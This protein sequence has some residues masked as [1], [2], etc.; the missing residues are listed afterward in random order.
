MLP[1]VP[2]AAPSVV[3]AL[4]KWGVPI[5]SGLLGG[6]GGKGRAQRSQHPT[7]T[8]YSNTA[9]KDPWDFNPE[10]AG[11]QGAEL[12]AALLQNWGGLMGNLGPSQ[13][14]QEHVNRGLRV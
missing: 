14:Y 7:R 3:P 13:Q 4:I 12:L 5:A 8:E 10:M 11:N 1:I 2:A 9:Q 6:I